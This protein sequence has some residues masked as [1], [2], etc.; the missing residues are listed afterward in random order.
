[1]LAGPN[2]ELAIASY[3]TSPGHENGYVL[4]R[5]ASEFTNFVVAIY[6]YTN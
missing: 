3:Y 2:N 1:M 6:I 4:Y 5:A